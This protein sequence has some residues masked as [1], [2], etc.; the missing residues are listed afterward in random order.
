MHDMC[1]RPAV[2]ESYTGSFQR[3]CGECVQH[4]YYFV[5]TCVVFAV[6]PTY[7]R[8]YTGQSAHLD[9]S[10]ARATPVEGHPGGELA[11]T[12]KRDARVLGVAAC[13]VEHVSPRGRL[14]ST[15]SD[16]LEALPPWDRRYTMYYVL[17][18]M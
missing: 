5:C 4:T 13:V 1:T 11:R 9:C 17:R 10:P 18:T 14:H 3:R 12:R 15:H 6:S 7:L 2:V 16:P 8:A